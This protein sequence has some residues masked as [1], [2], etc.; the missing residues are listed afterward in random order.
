MTYRYECIIERKDTR[1]T[2]SRDI[3]LITVELR[4]LERWYLKYNHGYV[5]V[6]YKVQSFI[7]LGFFYPWYFEHLDISRF[8]TNPI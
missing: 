3:H 5:E 6:I 8:L 7:F 4:Y 2:S 1:P